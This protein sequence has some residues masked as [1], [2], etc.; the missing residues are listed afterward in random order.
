LGSCG[1]D[2]LGLSWD[3]TDGASEYWVFQ[4]IDGGSAEQYAVV[5]SASGD[6]DGDGTWEWCD[7]DVD[8]QL[9]HCY[10]MT[11]VAESGQQSIASNEECQRPPRFHEGDI[12]VVA[13]TG[14]EGANLRDEG[15]AVIVTLPEGTRHE[16]RE[17]LL[18]GEGRTWLEVAN[19]ESVGYIDDEFLELA[20]PPA[21]TDVTVGYD[22]SVEWTYDTD[23]QEA[24]EITGFEIWGAQRITDNQF[25]FFDVIDTVSSGKLRSW[26]H[27]GASGHWCYQIVA[28]SAKYG[29]SSLSDSGCTPAP[30]E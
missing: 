25:G 11:G 10:F 22:D 18:Y 29:K 16:V 5:D 13:N 28:V 17:G 2:G 20:R 21:P 4:S 26:T 3:Y 9:A 14:G 15:G 12:V 6:P 19:L 24:W 30:V 8:L 1:K 23:D 27:T 7:D